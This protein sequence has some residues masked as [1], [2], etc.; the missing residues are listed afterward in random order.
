MSD[1]SIET[2][3]FEQEE[4]YYSNEIPDKLSDRRIDIIVLAGF[5]WLLPRKTLTVIN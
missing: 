1:R 3:T 2:F 4:C 5:L